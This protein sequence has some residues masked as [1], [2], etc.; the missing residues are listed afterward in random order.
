[1]PLSMN[2]EVFI[3]C[4]VTG[5]GDTVGAL[6][7]GAGH[8][9][10]DRRSPRSRRPRPGRR[11]CNATSAIR[12]PA[13]APA[14]RKTLPRGDGADPRGDVDVVLNL[15]AG[16]GGDIVFGDVEAP[17]PVNEKGTD[18]AGATERVAHVA[19]LPA[20]D[21][22]PRLRHDEL[23]RGRLRHDQHA[24]HAARDGAADD[25]RSGCGRRSRRSTPAICWFAK[26]LAARGAD[27]R[28]GADPAL[29]GHPVGRAG[30]PQHLHGDGQQRAGGLD[31]LGLL[32]RPQR[33][34]PIAALAVLAGGNVRVGL[35]DNLWLGKGELATNG[36]AGRA[37]GRRSCRHGR[38]G[39]GPAG[40]AR[41]S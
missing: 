17:F 33:S 41:R 11:S 3:T 19:E 10:T 27:R 12:R 30:R 18:M 2:R 38:A 24:R 28:S 23:R 14:I 34:S 16:M 5:A 22:H 40:G 26:Q 39:H 15:T 21:L 32:D 13:R 6:R 20:R 37:G 4:A 9:E 31:V 8:A 35:E 36:A 1:M 29:H 7:Q 25:R